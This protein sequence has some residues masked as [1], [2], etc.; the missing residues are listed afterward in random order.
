LPITLI[1]F[2]VTLQGN[3]NALLNWSTSNEV[4]NKGFNIEMA[5]SGNYNTMAFVAAKA[6]GASTNNYQTIVPNLAPGVYYF[7]LKIIGTNGQ[8]TYSPIRTVTITNSAAPDNVNIYPNPAKEGFV[9]LDVANNNKKITV[10]IINAVG[11]I[12][13]T[14]AYGNYNNP[15]KINVPSA[16]GI[17]NVQIITADGKTIIKKLIVIQ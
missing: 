2:T 16:A 1:S 3:N 8:F 6:S 5:A 17:Y 10:R 7:R 14:T 12:M 9:Y 15:L 13:S 4:N 11:Q